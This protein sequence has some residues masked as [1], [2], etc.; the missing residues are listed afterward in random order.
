MDML[1]GFKGLLIVSTDMHMVLILFHINNDVAGLLCH[2]CSGMGGTVA[3]M[4]SQGPEYFLKQTKANGGNSWK[5]K[6]TKEIQGYLAYSGFVVLIID[7][8]V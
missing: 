4:A 2:G 8:C 7:L 3:I 6:K 1:K 5:V